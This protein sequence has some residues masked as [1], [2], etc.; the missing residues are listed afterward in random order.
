MDQSLKSGNAHLIFSQ[1][2]RQ[3]FWYPLGL[4]SLLRYSPISSIQLTQVQIPLLLTLPEFCKH[5][6]EHQQLGNCS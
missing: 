3:H 2:L 6:G 5:F 4:R 1:L